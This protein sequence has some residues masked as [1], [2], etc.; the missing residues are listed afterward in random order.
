MSFDVYSNFKSNA[1]VSSVVFGAEKPILE[2]ELNELQE[3]GKYSLRNFINKIVGDGITNLSAIRYAGGI[4]TI[5]K[6]C[7]LIV[8]GIVIN[9]TGLSFNVLSAG[10][11]DNSIYLQVWEET[12]DSTKPFKE[13]G[14]QQSNITVPNWEVDSRISVETSRRK[15]VKYTLSNTKDSNKHNLL[16]ARIKLNLTDTSIWTLTKCV[17]EV[18]LKDV[19]RLLDTV[20]AKRH[21][22]INIYKN[23]LKMSKSSFDKSVCNICNGLNEM[24]CV[25][26][27]KGNIRHTKDFVTYFGDSYGLDSSLVYDVICCGKDR[28]IAVGYKYISTTLTSKAFYSL[29]GYNWVE[30]KGL[31]P[32]VRILDIAYGGGKFILVGENG[33]SYYSFDG[34]TLMS[35]TGLEK[36]NYDKIC[37]GDGKFLAVCGSS[38][39]VAIHDV[40]SIAI[41]KWDLSSYDSTYISC[42]NFYKGRF[43]IGG[44]N[45]DNTKAVIGVS[46]EHTLSN[47]TWYSKDTNVGGSFDNI[48]FDN[49]VIVAVDNLDSVVCTAKNFTREGEVESIVWVEENPLGID[50]TKGDSVTFLKSVLGRLFVK[51]SS[52]GSIIPFDVEMSFTSIS[53]ALNYIFNSGLKLTT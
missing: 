43:V 14:N 40:N 38:K 7:S 18:N 25:S 41:N 26:D 9:C 34:Y 8:D 50:F 6:D 36:F 35:M 52:G 32:T 11:E 2:S 33:V 16:I 29:D 4:L 49:G 3:I 53:E 22:D 27:N 44:I 39:N 13:E 15:V 46:Y 19:D 5:D 31:S 51:T 23:S 42:V 48:A 24:F 28:I 47:W 45:S 1:G 30:M 12:V 20:Y 17:D 10:Q 21:S 37:F